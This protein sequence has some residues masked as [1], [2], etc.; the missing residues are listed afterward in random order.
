MVDNDYVLFFEG[1]PPHPAPGVRRTCA[2]EQWN[3]VRADAEFAEAAA[4]AAAAAAQCQPLW[5]LL[6][7][8]NRHGWPRNVVLV[9]GEALVAAGQRLAALAP[10]PLLADPPPARALLFCVTFAV[11]AS[12]SLE[13]PRSSSPEHRGV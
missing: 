10:A 12:Q 7:R 1:V 3:A 5:H 13:N 9:A 2:L 8:N 11:L 6:Q 4:A